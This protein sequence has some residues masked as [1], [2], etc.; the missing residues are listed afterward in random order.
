[1]EVTVADPRNTS[2][3][4]SNCGNIK[5]MPLSK[6]IYFCEGCGLNEDRGINASINIHNRATIGQRVSHACGE[7]ARPQNE[8][9]LEELRTD[10]IHPLQDAVIT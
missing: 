8:A 2:R 3:M 1:M 9:L 10:K 5:S 6:R 4:H 7:N